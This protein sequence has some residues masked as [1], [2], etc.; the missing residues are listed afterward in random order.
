[1]FVTFLPL[2]P[3]NATRQFESVQTED[4]F[5]RVVNHTDGLLTTGWRTEEGL[6][7]GFHLIRFSDSTI[8]LMKARYKFWFGKQ[9]I[10]H[11]EG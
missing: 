6:K 10:D 4:G 9:E 1:M 7:E 5:F 11:K 3:N 2:D 8:E